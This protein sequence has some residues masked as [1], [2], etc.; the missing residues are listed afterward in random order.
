M[1][2]EEGAIRHQPPVFVGQ[3]TADAG[4]IRRTR[5]RVVCCAQP[6]VIVPDVYDDWMKAIRVMIQL[7]D[8][9]VSHVLHVRMQA[10][11]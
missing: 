9:E 6:S 10:A 5:E 8:Q 3:S 7:G 2:A 1:T 4:A 11:V